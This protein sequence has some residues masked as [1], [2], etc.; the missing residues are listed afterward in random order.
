MHVS[1]P[2]AL[3]SET[4][5]HRLSMWTRLGSAPRGTH[6]VSGRTVVFCGLG[7][8]NNVLHAH[9]PADVNISLVSNGLT[10]VL[11][12]LGTSARLDIDEPALLHLIG[13]EIFPVDSLC[14]IKQIVERQVEQCLYPLLS[15][16]LIVNKMIHRGGPV[17]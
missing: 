5:V 16:S 11:A 17:E 14:L 13:F 3:T 6:A 1:S 9:Q 4:I 2:S 15:P 8:S 12:I 10:A 7:I